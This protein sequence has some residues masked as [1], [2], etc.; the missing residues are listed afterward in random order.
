MTSHQPIT[1]HLALSSESDTSCTSSGS[2]SDLQNIIVKYKKYL[3]HCYCAN[4]VNWAVDTGGLQTGRKKARKYPKMP[5]FS[6]SGSTFMI[7][8]PRA[9]NLL[10]CL[11]SGV[12]VVR[13]WNCGDDKVKVFVCEHARNGRTRN[14][15]RSRDRVIV[16]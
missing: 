9:E 8:F 1:A 5:L 11:S 7:C 13:C 12:C 15:T 6:A 2:Q 4:L 16:C 10:F 14:V 3:F